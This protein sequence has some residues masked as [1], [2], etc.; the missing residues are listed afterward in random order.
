MGLQVAVAAPFK[1]RG[2]DRIAESEF[3]VALSLD[4]DWFSPDQ[5]KRLVDLAVGEGLLA[6][7]NGDLV[8]G[9]DFEDVEIPEGFT[10]D[11]SLLTERSPFE[12]VLDAAVAAG[13][14]KRE[15][16]AGINERQSRLGVAVE[17]AAVVYAREHG[18]DVDGVAES[19]RAELLDGDGESEPAPEREA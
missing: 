15:A 12:R 14:E 6:H 8:A 3:V 2:T 13:T 10:P 11:E 5:A 16:V 4:R 19:A 7:E 1:G 17:A 9:F 18:L